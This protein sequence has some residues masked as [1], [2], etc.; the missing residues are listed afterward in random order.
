VVGWSSQRP[1]RRVC[2]VV[3]EGWAKKGLRRFGRGGSYG[4]SGEPGQ[5]IPTF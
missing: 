1:G 3:V 2:T 5:V 4:I